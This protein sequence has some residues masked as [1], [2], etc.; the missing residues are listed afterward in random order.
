[1]SSNPSPVYSTPDAAPKGFTPA[2]PVGTVSAT[3]VMM[4]FGKD[5]T[6]V[7]YTPAFSGKVLITVTGYS[8]TNTA[9]AGMSI[10]GRFG[11]GTAPANGDAVTGTRFGAVGDPSMACAVAGIPVGW[12]LTAVLALTAGTTYWFDM[13][14][15]TTNASD[16]AGMRNVGFSIAELG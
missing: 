5:A 9:V 10:G 11:T 14:M 12:S 2:N 16:Q 4:G 13:A 1:M 8:F 6:P 15:S 7:A 3:L